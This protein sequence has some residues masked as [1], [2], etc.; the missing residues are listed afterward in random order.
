MRGS[1][2]SGTW[3]LLCGAAIFVFLGYVFEIH[4]P[5]LAGDFR[6]S[7]YSARCSIHRGCDPYADADVFRMYAQQ[8]PV[9]PVSRFVV[10]RYVY[11]PT[12]FIFTIP[13]ALL[14]VGAAHVV[15]VL[16]A[17]ASMILAAFLM[18]NSGQD[19]AS[20]LSGILLGFLLANSGLVLA[21]GNPAG[22][23]IGFC[24]IAVW[25]FIND[26]FVP[27]GLV[28]L[29][30]A[31]AVKPHDA[32]LV[33]LYL[34]IAGGTLRKGAIRALAVYA[35]FTVPLILWTTHISPHWLS[36][37]RSNLE[38]SFQRGGLN[39]PGPSS[40]TGHGVIRL[41]DLQTAISIFKDDPHFYNTI[42]YGLCGLL[43]LTW[44]VAI[45]RSR[46]N[47]VEFWLVFAGVSALSMASSFHRPYD[48]KLLM[49]MV[50]AFAMLWNEKGPVRWAALLF[51]G[52]AISAI[53]DLPLALL[54]LF[55]QRVPPSSDSFFGKLVTILVWNPTPV[56]LLAASIFFLW[57]FVRQDALALSAVAGS[58]NPSTRGVTA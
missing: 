44:A 6:A 47:A 46:R 24:V 20:L 28:C 27:A 8:E 32:G 29:A 40:F 53:G 35:A 17:A 43:F 14:P 19:Q 13:F 2:L 41:I 55:A 58:A 15:W 57:A 33:W 39:D 48:A 11:P 26:R 23:I 31:L 34:L 38:W 22:M 54:T 36:E 18:L 1:R 4:T 9:A 16:L 21:I 30:I 10:T 45:L 52:A 12:A 50:P 7:Y 49:L 3:A 25:C 37:L 56:I 51:T 42:T 5:A